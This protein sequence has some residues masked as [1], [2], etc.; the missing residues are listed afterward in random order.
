[1]IFG[2]L[3][4]SMFRK[5]VIEFHS[6]EI[7]RILDEYTVLIG[8]MVASISLECVMDKVNKHAEVTT[9]KTR[10]YSTHAR[11]I[12]N[13]HEMEHFRRAAVRYFTIEEDDLDHA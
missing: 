13:Q 4:D 3:E 8:L 6:S 2:D 1:M 5:E 7:L 11:A 9:T 10:V 12:P